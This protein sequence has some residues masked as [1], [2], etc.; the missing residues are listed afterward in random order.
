MNNATARSIFRWAHIVFG[1]P[2][3]G[4][5][6]SP[7]EELPKYAPRVRFVFVPILLFLGLWMWKGHVL[8]RLISKN[9]PDKTPQRL[10]SCDV[11]GINK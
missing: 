3:I 11:E 9:R 7:F 6:Y 4:Y 8:Q 1:I 10:S 2:V 5:I